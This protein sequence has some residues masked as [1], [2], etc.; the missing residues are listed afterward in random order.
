MA[1][2]AVLGRLR[3]PLTWRAAE[4]VEVVPETPRTKTVRLDVPDWPGH[5]AGQHIDVRLTAEDGYQAQRSYSIAS[6]PG[7]DVLELTVERIEDG[8]VSPYLTGEVRP[9][10]RFE[11]RGPVGG[12]FVWEPS[13]GGPLLLVAGGSG[14]VPL[15]AMLRHLRDEG[16]GVEATLLFSSRSW[17][18][19]IYR[20]ELEGL[21]GNGVRIVHT[22]TRSQP[23]GWRGYTRRIDAEMLAEVGPAPDGRPHIY[24]C[25]P[26]PFVEAAA[27]ALVDLDHEAARIRTERFGPTGG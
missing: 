17:D 23:D 15:M 5:L 14:I 11:L 16:G 7:A 8:E 20:D 3:A 1:G 26:T 12:Y 24:V 27:T 9:G 25:G 18:D 19:V 2:T 6:A 4:V 10:D 22:L 21:E 13:R